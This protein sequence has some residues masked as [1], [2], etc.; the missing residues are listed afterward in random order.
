MT[1]DPETCLRYQGATVV[2]FVFS[3]LITLGIFVSYL[4]QYKRIRQ[5]RTSEGL[6]TQFLFL[7]SC[8]SIFTITNILLVSSTARQCC[9]TGQL[10][11]FSCISSQLNLL[12]IST[13]CVCAI[14]ILVFVLSWTRNSIKQD[15]QEYV[16][17]VQVGKL[18]LAH[19]IISIIEIVVGFLSNNNVL[20][21]IANANGLLST[22]L[23]IIKYVPQILTTYHLKHP[24]TLSIGMMCIQTPGGMVFAANL[25]FSKGSHW[26]SWVSYVV[27]ATLQGILLGMCLYYEYF[28]PNNVDT[29]TSER[30]N[31]ERI[32]EANLSDHQHE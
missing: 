1:I 14:M 32:I 26:S 7:G 29:E 19:M 13:Q 8:S 5:K 21:T 27:A 30:L 17:N 20:L 15:K 25:L 11:K 4:P 28:N 22:L 18:V 2:N 16:R 3:L 24:G 23:T 9:R 10:N 31:V 6:S 12:Q